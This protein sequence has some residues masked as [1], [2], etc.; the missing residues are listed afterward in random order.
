MTD[1]GALA[2][3]A[4]QYMRAGDYGGAAA[5]FLAASRAAPL[6][7]DFPSALGDAYVSLGNYEDAESAYHRAIEISP[8]YGQAYFGLGEVTMRHTRARHPRGTAVRWFRDGVAILPNV[9]TAWLLLGAAQ[10]EE[11]YE[12][13]ANREALLEGAIASLRTALQLEP[14]DATTHWQLGEV[15]TARGERRLGV[16]SMAMAVRLRPDHVEALSSLAR[17]LSYEALSPLAHRLAKWAFRRA[18]AAAPAHLET[19]HNLGE[20]LYTESNSAG[21]AIAFRRATLISP[22]SGAS[23]LTLGESLQR[24]CRTEEANAHYV[25]AA[26]LLPRS[27]R[28]QVHALLSASKTTQPHVEAEVAAYVDTSEEA[29][30][31]AAIADGTAPR[32]AR[33]P[34]PP[35][36]ALRVEPR[37]VFKETGSH[38]VWRR[39]A[40]DIL[41]EHGVVVLTGLLPRGACAALLQQISAW[42]DEA[43]GTS[44]TTRQPHR[45]RHQALPMFANASGTAATL[46]KER[47]G[48]VL[49]LAFG[50]PNV[51]LVECGYLSS[52]PGAQAQAMH[53]DTAPARLRACESRAIKIQLALVDVSAAMGPL[54]VVPGSHEDHATPTPQLQQAG[55]KS[56]AD[57]TIAPTEE[58]PILAMPL[59]VGPG[60]VTLYWSSLMHRGGANTAER[61]RPTF[62]MAA[63]G[64]GGAPTGMPY[65]VLV[66]D[67][68]TMYAHGQ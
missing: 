5:S 62:H 2:R 4:E 19:W 65:T 23:H 68:V 31:V 66:D 35:P 39:A 24:M 52:E 7:P 55:G 42:P 21:A 27:A 26:R 25:H 43:E 48:R 61:G 57:G 40:V 29:A 38:L 51:R 34:L 15:L 63:I 17:V 9:P 11:A 18:L 49:E 36:S 1:V 41:Q 14:L 30:H 46:I 28:A 58:A 64:D 33:P 59:L 47:L 22:S 67:L 3:A 6:I 53:A 10:M 13:P 12:H 56:S 54:E 20:Y 45:R 32:R 16:Q 44:A 8:R 60:D 50:T 37:A